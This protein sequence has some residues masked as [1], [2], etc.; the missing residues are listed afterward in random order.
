M[1]MR[2]AISRV[3]VASVCEA[4]AVHGL[5]RKA[6]DTARAHLHQPWLALDIARV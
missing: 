3:S 1:V 5:R 6:H 4:A 2:K